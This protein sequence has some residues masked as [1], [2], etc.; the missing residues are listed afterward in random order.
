MLQI[1]RFEDSKALRFLIAG[2]GEVISAYNWKADINVTPRTSVTRDKILLNVF[3][4]LY[5]INCYTIFIN[6]A[7][8]PGEVAHR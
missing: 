8:M 6:S 4:S 7:P 2:A 3:I 5:L 1:G